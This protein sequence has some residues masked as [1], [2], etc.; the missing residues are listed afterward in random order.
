MYFVYQKNRQHNQKLAHLYEEVVKSRMQQATE[1]NL[2]PYYIDHGRDPLCVYD[3]EISIAESES[4]LE[5]IQVDGR[6]SVSSLVVVI[7]SPALDQQH[8]P[9]M[10]PLPTKPP[11]SYQSVPLGRAP[12]YHHYASCA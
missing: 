7:P 12:S 9:V 6:D 5:T 1:L 10:A 11:P 3:D 2:P 4:S 8:T